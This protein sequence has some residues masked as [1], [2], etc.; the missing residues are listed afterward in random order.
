[1]NAIEMKIWLEAQAILVEVEG[2]KAENAALQSHGKSPA[3][4]DDSFNDKAAQL[5]G[6]QAAL[7]E[8]WQN[9]HTT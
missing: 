8:Q 7:H 4:R 9:G 1:M 2:M 5:M 6:L 3:Y